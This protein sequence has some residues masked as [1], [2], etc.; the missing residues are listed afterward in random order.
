MRTSAGLI[1]DND[2]AES[3]DGRLDV[4][5]LCRMFEQSEDAT[6]TA[7]GKSERDRD[8]RRQIQHTAEEIATLKKR[9]QPIV[10]DNRIKTKIDFLVGLEKQQRIDPRALASHSAA[11]GGR[12]R[13]HPGAALRRRHRGLR[14][15]ALRAS[16][17]TCWWRAP[18]ES[19]SMSSRRAR[20]AT[21][22]GEMEIKIDY[23][24]WDRMFWD[25]HSLTAGLLRRRLSRHRDLDGLRR[26]AG[27]VPR[28][29]GSARHHDG[30]G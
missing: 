21:A 11:R 20:P 18:A 8:Y 5:D 24:S 28:W 3:D 15:Q 23:V 4:G 19:A 30:V 12:R 2:R 14:R 1:D 27:Q 29:Q 16:G 7:R 17:A 13:R 26:R 10:T 6:L 25:P 22:Q 9:G